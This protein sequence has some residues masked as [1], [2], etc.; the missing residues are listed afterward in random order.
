MS[1][2]HPNAHFIHILKSEVLGQIEETK[3]ML[4]TDI[5]MDSVSGVI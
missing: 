5:K 2:S 1:H 4:D 3:D